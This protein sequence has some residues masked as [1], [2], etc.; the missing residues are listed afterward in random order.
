MS[1][2][3]IPLLM[4]LGAQVI[5]QWPSNNVGVSH[6][7]WGNGDGRTLEK[8]VVSNGAVSCVNLGYPLE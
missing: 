5:D 2:L 1:E 6:V 7:L 3:Y 8:V 4:D